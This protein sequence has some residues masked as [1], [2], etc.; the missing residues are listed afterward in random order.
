MEGSYGRRSSVI[1]FAMAMEKSHP[2]KFEKSNIVCSSV[3]LTGAQNYG[4]DALLPK[5]HRRLPAVKGWMRGGGG[6]GGGG[7]WRAAR[8]FGRFIKGFRVGAGLKGRGRGGRDGVLDA[9]IVRRLR[10]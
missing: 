7:G 2:A 6:G 8:G 4:S 9:H 3:S 5:V 1:F 10:S